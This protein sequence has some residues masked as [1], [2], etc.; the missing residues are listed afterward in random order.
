VL[1][2]IEMR[3]KGGQKRRFFVF[4]FFRSSTEKHFF[5]EEV[6]LSLFHR[7]AFGKAVKEGDVNSATKVF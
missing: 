1:D 5:F 4:Y 7:L 3:E 6:Q 2:A